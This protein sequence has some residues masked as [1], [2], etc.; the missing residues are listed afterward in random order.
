MTF[1][2]LTQDK[3]Q[4]VASLYE[5]FK[6]YRRKYINCTFH[7]SDGHYNNP[8]ISKYLVAIIL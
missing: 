6:E 2:L 1:A 4:I 3:S 8:L 7:A 5:M